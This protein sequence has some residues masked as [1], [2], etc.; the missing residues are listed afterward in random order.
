MM[1]DTVY[2]SWTATPLRIDRQLKDQPQETTFV[3]MAHFA[4]TG[5]A[6]KVCGGCAFYPS[7]TKGKSCR[8]NEM[9]GG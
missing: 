8:L 2:S 9:G 7:K 5:P 6:G 1:G 3:G 4:G